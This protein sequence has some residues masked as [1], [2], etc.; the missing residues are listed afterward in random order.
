M[1]LICV[2]GIPG[3]QE[4]VAEANSCHSSDSHILYENIKTNIKEARRN[5]KFSQLQ[6]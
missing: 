4:Y 2:Q 1:S 6:A 3:W 5:A